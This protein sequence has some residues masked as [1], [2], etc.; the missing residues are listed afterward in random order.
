VHQELIL[1]GK[2]MKIIAQSEEGVILSGTQTKFIAL[3]KEGVVYLS[4]ALR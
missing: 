3:S 2:K 1:S 4:V